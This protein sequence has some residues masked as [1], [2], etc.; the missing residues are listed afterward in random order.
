VFDPGLGQV[1]A[2]FLVSR[3][4]Y[5]LRRRLQR[6]SLLDIAEFRAKTSG[7]INPA[8]TAGVIVADGLES[9]KT[10]AK[11]GPK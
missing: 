2:G 8:P 6:D 5:V 4:W 3:Y 9:R 11:T 10:A 7:A 1:R